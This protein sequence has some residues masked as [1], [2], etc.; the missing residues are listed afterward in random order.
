MDEQYYGEISCSR[1][2]EV[3]DDYVDGT[4]D[5]HD[6]QKVQTHVAQCENCANFGARYAALVNVLRSNHTAGDPA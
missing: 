3:L 1:V 5:P 4:L 2:L 6:L